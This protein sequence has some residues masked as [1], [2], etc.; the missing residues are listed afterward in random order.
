MEEKRISHKTYWPIVCICMWT[1]VYRVMTYFQGLK[2]TFPV[3][4]YSVDPPCIKCGQMLSWLRRFIKMDFF[5]ESVF[6]KYIKYQ[7][8]SPFHATQFFHFCRYEMQFCFVSLKLVTSNSEKQ[9][10]LQQAAGFIS[11]VVYPTP[12]LLPDPF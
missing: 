1:C 9:P 4:I 10:F 6:D 5:L 2:D 8:F 12:P 11:D 7:D 3:S